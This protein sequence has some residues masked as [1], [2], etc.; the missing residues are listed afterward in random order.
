VGDRMIKL[1]F[2]VPVLFFSHPRNW[3]AH[4]HWENSRHKKG[5]AFFNINALLLLV[6]ASAFQW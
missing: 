2:Y 6:L 1:G 3:L 5:V 4:I